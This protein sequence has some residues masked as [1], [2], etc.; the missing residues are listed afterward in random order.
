MSHQF[1]ISNK[2]VFFRLCI[3][4]I[5][6]IVILTPHFQLNS[7]STYIWISY[8]YVIQHLFFLPL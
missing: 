2:H 5:L 6:S 1:K 7:S 4:R 3:T 8:L